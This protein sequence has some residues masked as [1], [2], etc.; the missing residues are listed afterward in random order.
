MTLNSLNSPDDSREWPSRLPDALEPLVG[1]LGLTETNRHRMS[2]NEKH[3]FNMSPTV[4]SA[5]GACTTAGR[6]ARVRA[7]RRGGAHPRVNTRSTAEA[8]S[9][10]SRI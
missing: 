7:A 3:Q 1:G 8:E 2:P 5:N 10:L 6:A 9:C 4:L